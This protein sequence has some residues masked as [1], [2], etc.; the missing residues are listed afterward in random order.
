M[1]R[2]AQRPKTHFC[3]LLSPRREI[4]DV[5]DWG[6]SDTWNSLGGGCAGVSDHIAQHASF[7][8]TPGDFT[9]V[10]VDVT[11]DV[12][13]WHAKLDGSI[14]SGW[15]L[16]AK[17]TDGWDYKTLH[18]DDCKP[19]LT[20]FFTTRAPTQVPTAAPTYA[21]TSTPAP[22]IGHPVR[23]VG[24]GSEREGRVEILAR[25]AAG[26][27]PCRCPLRSPRTM[28]LPPR[29]PRRPRRRRP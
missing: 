8:F 3:S 2:R 29:H 22:T 20:V 4:G 7:E 25:P 16:R 28:A 14:N 19:T 12:Q 10:T 18:N 9:K 21:P 13:G 24:G 27:D 17:S 26:G 6:E 1:T 11:A 15:C 5:G 23:L